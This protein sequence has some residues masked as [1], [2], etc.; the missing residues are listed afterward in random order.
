MEE[1]LMKMIA[2]YKKHLDQSRDILHEL[3]QNKQ[4]WTVKFEIHTA[5]EK[6]WKLAL[7]D[8]KK[9]ADRYKH[10]HPK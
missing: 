8:F 1:L 6:F 5:Y 3:R 7:N 2:D 4:E 9:L 10:D